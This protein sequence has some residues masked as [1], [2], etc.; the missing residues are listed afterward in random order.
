MRVDVSYSTV[1][2]NTGAESDEITS[3]LD[4]MNRLVV[5][6]IEDMSLPK[7]IE[8]RPEV[9]LLG[10]FLSRKVSGIYEKLWEKYHERLP[11]L[12]AS[13]NHYYR[14]AICGGGAIF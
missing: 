6:L 1:A 14:K 2:N 11:E 9:P 3:L 7:S 13:A 4:E 8:L 5:K 12:T 10:N